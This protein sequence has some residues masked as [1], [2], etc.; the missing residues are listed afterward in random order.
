M[1]LYTVMRDDDT[2]YSY[3]YITKDT[4]GRIAHSELVGH[5]ESKYCISRKKA[6]RLCFAQGS[7]GC[8]SRAVTI[9][10]HQ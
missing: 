5:I 3:L 9:R 10:S 6:T 2:I 7:V 4:H 8:E 1:I